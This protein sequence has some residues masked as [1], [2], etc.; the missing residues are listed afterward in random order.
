MRNH[1]VVCCGPT[2][3]ETVTR[4]E[5]LEAACITFFRNAINSRISQGSEPYLTE[6]LTLLDQLR[7]M[8]FAQ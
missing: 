3:D 1:G 7:E 5:A 6:V 4:V 8:E 2:L